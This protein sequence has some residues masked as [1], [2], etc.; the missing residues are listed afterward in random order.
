MK[1]NLE[2]P[3]RNDIDQ[4]KISLCPKVISQEIK[5][6]V[7]YPDLIQDTVS[8]IF[9]CTDSI[10]ELDSNTIL[11]LEAKTGIDGSGSH[12]ARHQLVNIEKSLDENPHLDPT[13]YKNF[14][15][16]CV[17]PLSLPLVNPSDKVLIW[18]IPC[19]NSISYT[20]P[21]CLVRTNETRYVIEREFDS[22]FKNI[23]D[24]HSQSITIS[25]FPQNLSLQIKNTVSMIDGKMVSML[26]GDSGGYCHYCCASR[27]EG[28]SLCCILQGFN[29]TKS[30]QYCQESWQRITS[31]EMQWKDIERAGQCHEPLVEINLFSILHWKLRAFDFALA[32]LYRLC[33]GVTLW[34]ESDKRQLQFVNNSKKE[35]QDNIQSKLGILLDVPTAGGGTTNNGPMAERFFSHE[36]RETICELIRNREDKNNFKKFIGDINVLLSV[37]SS[38]SKKCVNTEMI[39]Q[40]G[41]EI[42]SHLRTKFLDNRGQPW[43][44]ISPS[45]HQMCAHSWQL[46]QISFP[47][48]IIIYSEQSQEAWNKYISKF[49]SGTGARARQHSVKYNIQDTFKRMLHMM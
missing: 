49:K 14:L 17:C 32:L 1:Y 30:Y 5:S 41:I 11:H 34:G 4:E 15:L 47:K 12:R 2:L 38:T 48:P 22:L 29:I 44:V 28:N 35:F 19:P 25:K 24:T 23:M 39:R 37:C 33:A 7:T 26:Q 16:C 13:L 21:L 8:G 10:V 36:N 42:M 43:V 40:L 45:L 9:E 6:F 27:D 3:T 46:F 18:K 31:G 20:R